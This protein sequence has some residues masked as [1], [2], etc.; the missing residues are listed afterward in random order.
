MNIYSVLDYELVNGVFNIGDYVQSLAAT[1]FLPRVDQYISRERL[2]SYSGPRTKIIL[3][4]WFMHNPK[5]WPPSENIDPLMVSFHINRPFIQQMLS[6]QGVE[7]LKKNEPV[8]C[9]DYHTCNILRQKGIEAYYSG[10][11]TLTLGDNYQ[12]AQERKNVLFVDVCHAVPKLSSYLNMKPRYLGS[13]LLSGNVPRSISRSSVINKIVAASEVDDDNNIEFLENSI[14]G[15]NLSTDEKFRCADEY[16]KK[17]AS[18]KVVYTSRIHC[19]LPCLAI[20]IP[21]VFIKYGQKSSSN[22]LRF[23]GI[24]DHMNV[25]D[26]DGDLKRNG[27][28]SKFLSLGDISSKKVQS[29]P[30]T[31]LK[32]AA[33]LRERCNNFISPEIR[34]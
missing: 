26:L 13:H 21:V 2:N 17:I 15:S 14:N 29:N 34:V 5:N 16:L 31:H 3:N 7:F 9:R 23:R 8:G 30:N 6:S 32:L 33:K 1:N 4:G 22:L 20:G 11:L 24:L 25:L 18:A 12:K 27:F 10:C 28:K 19:A